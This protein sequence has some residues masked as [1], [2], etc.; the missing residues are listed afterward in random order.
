MK[1]PFAV[2]FR[3][4]ATA[5]TLL[6]APFSCQAKT[7][8]VEQREQG[9]DLTGRETGQDTLIGG[10]GND[11]LVVLGEN[12]VVKGNDG[13]DVL[14]GRGGND[15]LY[16]GDGNDSITSGALG[17]S[18]LVGGDGNDRLEG[19]K[20][21]ND[22]LDGGSGNDI[23]RLAGGRQVAD[24][25]TG[26]DG[27]DLFDYSA[28]IAYLLAGGIGPS[29]GDAVTDFVVGSDLLGIFESQLEG[30]ALVDSNKIMFK[31]KQ[32]VV[33]LKFAQQPPAD[34]TLS[35]LVTFL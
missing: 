18:T 6:A 8:V 13:N 1:L 7:V 5:L 23:L 21:G 10:A 12:N 35:D 31:G 3:L 33:V 16:G 20:G 30:L 27:D 9:L 32:V 25:L 14:I 15:V 29:G 26:G 17:G 34:L 4:L 22:T 19:G 24:R 2:L 28:V 11:R